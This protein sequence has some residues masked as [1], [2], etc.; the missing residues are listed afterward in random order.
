M[1]NENSAA[2]SH[3]AILFLKKFQPNYFSNISLIK[4]F[5]RLP[6]CESATHLILGNIVRAVA[7][8]R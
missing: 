1:R 6:F 7:V 5:L 4:N 2:A 8:L 3:G